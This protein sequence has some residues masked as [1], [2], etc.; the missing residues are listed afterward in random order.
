MSVAPALTVV[1]VSRVNRGTCEII[2]ASGQTLTAEPTGA[3][4]YRAQSALDLP[5][6]GDWAEVDILGDTA[7]IHALLPR[8]TAFVRRAAGT[9]EEPQ[10]IA[11][12]IDLA[13]IVC[14]LDGDFNLR[15]IERY[16]TLAREAGAE[17][18]VI[19]N[20]ADLAE[21]VTASLDQVRRACPG[22]CV[23]ATQATSRAGVDPVAALVGNGVTAALLGSSGAGKSTLVN[24]LL[25]APRHETQEV[26]AHDS[27]GRHTTTFRQLVLLPA[28]GALI[29]TPGLR[30]LQLWASEESL[31]STFPDIA[32][33]AALCRYRDCT[34]ATEPACAVA[35]AL[36]AGSLDRQRW[37]SY[38]KLV[39]EIRRHELANDHVAAR[40]SKQQ[41]KSLH[42][43]Y[44]NFDKAR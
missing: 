17:P 13:L 24:Q 2:T 10:V 38:Q 36:L 33:L 34:H 5:A 1:R 22:L 12:N 30:E 25:G 44:R 43:A 21:N 11:A 3:L 20:K 35:A 31:D 27:R 14:G 41:L 32:A 15:R 40:R 23:L 28:G 18:A 16:I 39:R 42:K 6:V 26:R 9:R 7:L 4:V 8:R 29:D 19:L 37:E